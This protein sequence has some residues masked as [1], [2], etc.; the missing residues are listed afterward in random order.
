MSKAIDTLKFWKD[1]IKHAKIDGVMHYSVYLKATM[2]DIDVRHRAIIRKLGINKPGVRVLDAGCGYG[3][4]AEWFPIENYLGIDFSPDF[5][6]EAVVRYPKYVF[7]VA[8]LTKELPFEANH[9]DWAVFNSIRQMV[10]GNLAPEVWETM[11]A[12]AKRVAKKVLI[13]EYVAPEQYE[14]L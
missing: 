3:R 6:D 5:I 10:Q 12:N 7:Q 13:L 11:L 2:S 4:N 1:R 14:I 8:D 9:F